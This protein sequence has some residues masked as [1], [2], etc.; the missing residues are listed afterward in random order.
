M[1]AAL[2]LSGCSTLWTASSGLGTEDEPAIEVAADTAGGENTGTLA[3]A[4]G[5]VDSGVMP[6]TM[7]EYLQLAPE[8]GTTAHVQGWFYEQDGRAQVCGYTIESD[9]PQCVDGVAITG[10]PEDVWVESSGNVRWNTRVTSLE[11][12]TVSANEVA[13]I[14]LSDSVG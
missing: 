14:E 7:S 10:L 2:I 13:L 12:Q 9:P 11:V 8:P 1:S 4:S 5:I 3:Q 6:F